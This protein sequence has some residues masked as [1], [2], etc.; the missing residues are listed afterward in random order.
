MPISTL[1]AAKILIFPRFPENGIEP[2]DTAEGILL[3]ETPPK[4]TL[5]VVLVSERL[6]SVVVPILIK[7]PSPTALIFPNA[8]TVIFPPKPV[9][10][11]P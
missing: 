9:P 5:P 2:D 8:E 11:L 7:E 10:P 6:P 3:T 4:E 1:P